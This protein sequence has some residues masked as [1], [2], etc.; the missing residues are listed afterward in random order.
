[1]MLE[2]EKWMREALL[3]AELAKEEKEVP[4]GA[5]VV[6]AGKIIG[7]GHNRVETL[8]DPTA[9]AEIIAMTSA[10]NT[11]GDWRLNK[12]TLYVTLEPCPMCAGAILISRM[13]RCVFG[14]KDISLGSLGSVYSIKSPE[15]AI[16]SGVLKSECQEILRNFFKIV[17]RKDEVEGWP[18]G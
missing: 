4:V 13:K 12:S 5:V 16:T 7:R 8:K 1:M 9:H 18:S 11:L 3:E 2:D 10:C 14:V 17:R 6:Q 15:I